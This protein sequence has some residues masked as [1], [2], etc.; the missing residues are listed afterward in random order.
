MRR[1]KETRYI[2]SWGLAF[3]EE[4]EMKKLSNWASKGWLFESFGF[5][6]FKLRKGEAQNLVYSID[7]N[8]LQANELQDYYDTFR[9]AGWEAVCSLSN[10]HVFSAKPGTVP[11]YTDRATS[12]DK[13]NRAIVNFKWSSLLFGLLTLI[14]FAA[15]YYSDNYGL[16]IALT[17][18]LLIFATLCLMIALPSAMVYCAYRFRKMRLK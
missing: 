16:G 6:G 12:Y 7:Y 10:I 17:Q 5:L 1:N 18:V 8:T 2:G 11:I 3:A 9:A 15:Y 14:G 13:Y 4:K